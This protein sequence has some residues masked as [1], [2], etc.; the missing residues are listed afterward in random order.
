MSLEIVWH[1][2][3]EEDLRHIPWQDAA[4]VVRETVKLG[5]DGVGDVRAATLPTG[6]RVFRLVLSGVRVLVTFDRPGKTLHV[7]RV[8]LSGRP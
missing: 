7:W 4:W 6:E 2:P 3:A 5:E 8:L 1:P